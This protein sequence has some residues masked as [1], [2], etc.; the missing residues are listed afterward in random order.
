MPR[1]FPGQSD[2]ARD[3]QRRRCARTA[4]SA[5]PPSRS[6]QQSG[7]GRAFSDHDVPR[8]PRPFTGVFWLAGRGRVLINRS[9][10]AQTKMKQG[11]VRAVLFLFTLLFRCALVMNTE[12]LLAGSMQLLGGA[13]PPRAQWSAPSRTTSHVRRYARKTSH[14][15]VNGVSVD[16]MPPLRVSLC[17]L[18]GLG[19][20]LLLHRF[21]L[22]RGASG[23]RTQ[24]RCG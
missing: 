6:L 24:R 3:R 14:Q 4:F 15:T 21:G 16:K 7:G 18:G 11:L 22:G 20:R 17:G 5:A 9:S 13:R 1:S 10:F 8:C 19:V 2:H 23:Q 12:T